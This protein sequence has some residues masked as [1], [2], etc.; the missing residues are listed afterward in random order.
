MAGTTYKVMKAK[1]MNSGKTAWHQI[2]TVVIREGGQNGVL[3]LTWLEGD[4]PLFLKD[5]ARDGDDVSQPARNG[6]G[7]RRS[8]PAQ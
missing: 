8:E 6:A 1:A 2:G 3:F 4:Y 7:E 5:E